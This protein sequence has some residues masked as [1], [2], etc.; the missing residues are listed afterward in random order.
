MLLQVQLEWRKNCGNSDCGYMF[1]CSPCNFDLQL[2]PGE[3]PQEGIRG[4]A[5][6]SFFDT[7]VLCFE[8]LSLPVRLLCRGWA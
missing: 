4:L 8:V 3:A 6:E 1:C 7:V 2:L 5:R